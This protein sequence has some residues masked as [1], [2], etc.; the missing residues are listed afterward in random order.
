M[1]RFGR[2]KPSS[3]DAK[4]S[5]PG[6]IEISRRTQRGKPSPWSVIWI[7]TCRDPR[8]SLPVVISKEEALH[9]KVCTDDRSNARH[10]GKRL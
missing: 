8:S 7:T 6:R 9:E 1:D 5:S 3:R 4:S 10:W 2:P